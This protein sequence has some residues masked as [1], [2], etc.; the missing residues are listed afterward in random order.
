MHKLLLKQQLSRLKDYLTFAEQQMKKYG[1]IGPDYMAVQDQVEEHQ[2]G[3]DY[4][5]WFED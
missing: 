2:V 1:P 5:T 4:L 3:C